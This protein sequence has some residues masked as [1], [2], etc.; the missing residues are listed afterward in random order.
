MTPAVCDSAGSTTAL[1][2]IEPYGLDQMYVLKGHLFINTS[3]NKLINTSVNTTFQEDMFFNLPRNRPRA[4]LVINYY[5]LS[6]IM[7]K[8][9]NVDGR[10][11]SEKF[12]SMLCMCNTHCVC[13]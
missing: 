6:L 8:K 12:N 13:R 4:N 7:M 9:S 3:V 5:K 1:A 11:A 10:Y 2:L